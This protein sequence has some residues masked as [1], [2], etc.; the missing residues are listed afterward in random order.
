M[1]TALKRICCTSIDLLLPSCSWNNHL[2]GISTV[3]LP[4]RPGAIG[5]DASGAGGV[6]ADENVFSPAFLTISRQK[7][8]FPQTPSVFPHMTFQSLGYVMERAAAF[9]VCPPSVLGYV[10][11]FVTAVLAEM[12]GEEGGRRGKEGFVGNLFN[13]GNPTSASTAK[14]GFVGNHLQFC[15]HWRQLG[16]AGSGWE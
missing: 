14:E 5:T 3:V 7:V 12:E 2:Q 1:H 10:R 11:V 13:I 15:P 4:T 6:W 16:T 8:Q 9:R